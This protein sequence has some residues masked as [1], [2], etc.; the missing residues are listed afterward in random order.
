MHAMK[1]AEASKLINGLYALI[2][3]EPHV[4]A[5]RE[6]QAKAILL[7]IRRA[8][9]KQSQLR[10]KVGFVRAGFELWF[11]TRRLADSGADAKRVKRNLYTDIARLDNALTTAIRRENG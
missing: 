6:R 3:A 10:E 7:K 1:K 11:H 9:W 5:T 4:N 8:F 2:G